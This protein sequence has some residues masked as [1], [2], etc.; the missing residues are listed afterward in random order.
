MRDLHVDSRDLQ[1][2]ANRIMHFLDAGIQ[3]PFGYLSRSHRTSGQ[4]PENLDSRRREIANRGGAREET[5]LHHWLILK[6]KKRVHRRISLKKI[7]RFW[8]RGDVPAK[9]L[10]RASTWGMWTR[11]ITGAI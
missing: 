3:P 10:P 1:G 4:M 6:L 11:P 5:A 8:E 9:T 2:S 7:N